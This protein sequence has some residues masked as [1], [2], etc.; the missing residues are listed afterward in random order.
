VITIRIPGE[1]VAQ[2]RPRFGKGRVYDPAKSLN[3]KAAAQLHLLCAH[4]RKPF[5]RS[6]P[7]ALHVQAVFSCPKS[8]YRKREPRE[9]RWH[10]KMID[11]DNVLKAVMDAGTAILWEDDGQIVM[12]TL[13]KYVGA[14]GEAPYVELVVEE[15]EE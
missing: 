5:P 15:L 9:I 10:T 8:D 3:W 7:L 12:V 6:T 14:Q 2:G 13:E 11:A 4:G 1:P